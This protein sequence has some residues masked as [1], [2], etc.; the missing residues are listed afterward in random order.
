MHA[1]GPG[2]LPVTYLPSPGSHAKAQD[3]R[4]A[5]SAGVCCP[6]RA[7][8]ETAVPM[9]QGFGK[10]CIPPSMPW[11][12]TGAWTF[13]SVAEQPTLFYWM[14]IYLSITVPHGHIRNSNTVF[15][16]RCVEGERGG[17]GRPL[18]PV[19]ASVRGV[20]ATELSRSSSCVTGPRMQQKIRCFPW[21]LSWWKGFEKYCCLGI[22]VVST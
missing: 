3:S 22:Q 10:L 14:C 17:V 1:P 12:H 9:Q 18:A 7:S 15:Y 6:Q 4:K 8:Q 5:T 21:D 13:K 2:F 11:D 19:Q 20:S 16:W